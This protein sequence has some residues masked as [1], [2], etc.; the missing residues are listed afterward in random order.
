M[1]RVASRKW[2]LFAAM[3]FIA[4]LVF[5][6]AFSLHERSIRPQ[7]PSFDGVGDA[8]VRI[9]EFSF[10][11]AKDGASAWRLTAQHA[12]LFEKSQKTFLK[13][14]SAKIPYGADRILQI[15]GDSGEVDAKRQGFSLWKNNGQMAIEL[16]N[17]YTVK[18][19]GLT[20]DDG[21]RA[22]LSKGP[23]HISGPWTEIEGDAFKISVEDQVMVVVGNVKA[24]VK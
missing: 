16:E 10:V 11:Q 20:W 14:V 18:T 12:E 8:D 13:S 24:L 7:H 9:R 19:S 23:V 5:L 1:P 6:S 3:G 2:L 22:V 21:Q 15:D 17:N 4:F